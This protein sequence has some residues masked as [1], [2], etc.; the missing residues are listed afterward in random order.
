M[1]VASVA[2]IVVMLAIPMALAVWLLR[3]IPKAPPRRYASKQPTAPQP[4]ET[5]PSP[6]RRVNWLAWIASGIALAAPIVFAAFVYYRA[7]GCID[8]DDTRL[9][10]WAAV[11]EI[12]VIL[13]LLYQQSEAKRLAEGGGQPNIFAA[14]LLRRSRSW[15][16]DPATDKQISFIHD[17]GGATY[18]G[19]T[20]GEASTLIDSLLAARRN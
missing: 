9:L 13:F 19:M 16:A 4:A 18:E 17:L 14:L 8:A 11:A 7:D 1:T 3:G 5:P 2:L 10:V 20:K 12:I 15:K 6:Q